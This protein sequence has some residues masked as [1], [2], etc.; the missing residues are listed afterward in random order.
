MWNRVLPCLAVAAALV[1]AGACCLAPADALASGGASVKAE[2]DE[3]HGGGMNPLDPAAW[4]LDLAL[5]TFVVFVVL[6]AVLG[7]FAWKP[8]AAGLDKRERGVAQ[9]IAQA[10]AAN[11][12]ARQ[13]LADYEQKLAAARDE[14][15]GILDEARR[16]AE[17]LGKDLLDKAHADAEAER[18]RALRE[19]DT[20]TAHA[21]KEIADRTATMAVDLAGR[22]VHAKLNPKDHVKLIEQAI[23]NYVGGP[24][25]R[26]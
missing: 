23:G 4:K 16:D 10:E 3:A 13:L 25:S 11:Q 18:Q 8:L 24:P 17:R 12:Q 20:A 15:R 21:L 26:N 2:A 22:I 7:K 6:L 5:W 9:Q 1:A 14:V 19:I